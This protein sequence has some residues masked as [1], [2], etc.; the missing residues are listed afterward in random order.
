MTTWTDDEHDRAGT[1][2]ITSGTLTDHK[3]KVPTTRKKIQ[4]P[5]NAKGLLDEHFHAGLQA[6]V[7]L[8]PGEGPSEQVTSH[9]SVCSIGRKSHEGF[10]YP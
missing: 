9:K 10:L 2:E 5:P 8:R 7:P 6:T 3:D 1:P 4:V